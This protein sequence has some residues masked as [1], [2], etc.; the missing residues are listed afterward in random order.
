[1]MFAFSAHFCRLL[2]ATWPISLHILVTRLRSQ[3]L[4]LG[5]WP[6]TGLIMPLALSFCRCIN[7]IVA[8]CIPQIHVPFQASH[9]LTVASSSGD[10]MIQLSAKES[11]YMTYA[12][13]C[14]FAQ[15]F[16]SPRS[17]ARN[18]RKLSSWIRGSLMFLT[19]R[20]RF[21]A[22]ISCTRNDC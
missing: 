2:V 11:R 19:C 6:R 21:F 10:I 1:M 9:F 5:S 22:W 14:L 15:L 7:P 17:V 16:V 8:G 20:S 18:Q 3:S 4:A 12:S 13:G